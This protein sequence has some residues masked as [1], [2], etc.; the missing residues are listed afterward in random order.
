M[1]REIK[2]LRSEG[3]GLADIKR[4]LMNGKKMGH[5][6]FG[7]IDLLANRVAEIVKAEVCEFFKEG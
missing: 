2:E 1:L 7:Q 5:L 3:T 6:K 4:E